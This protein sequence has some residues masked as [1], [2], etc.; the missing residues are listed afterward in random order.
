MSEHAYTNHLINETSPYLLQHAHNP[1]DWYPWGEEAL[2]R[3]HTEDKP[4][5]LSIGYS[6]CHWCHVMEHESFEDPR[7][8][9][10]MN[11]HFVNIKVDREERPDLDAIYMQAVQAMTGQGGWPMTTFLTPQGQPFYGGT[12]YPPEPRH[13]LPG[14]TQLLKHINNLWQTRR[15]EV[16]ET[17]GQ[18]A[19]TLQASLQIAG[20]AQPLDPSI[21]DQAYAVLPERYDRRYGGWGNAPKFP[22]PQT[23][24]FVLRHYLRTGD[25]DGLAMAVHTLDTMARGGMYDQLG[26]GFHRYSVDERWLVPHFE[27]MLYD[28]AQ[29]ARV[30]LHAYQITG[31]AFYRRIVEETLDYV[32]REMTAPEGGFYATQ[33]A[34][35]EGEEGKFFVWTADEVRSVLGLDALRWMQLY[36]V[37]T[38]GN[39]EGKTILNLPRPLEEVARVLG[40]RPAQLE[41]L[42]ARGRAK[43]FAVREQ[44]VHPGRD[45]KVLVAWNG[46]MLAAM[47]EVGRVL[48]RDDYIRA[49]KHNAEFVLGTL[50]HDGQ[51]WHVY[52]D[53]QAKI[54]GF[55]EDY[56]L[57][58]DGLLALYHAT[59]EMRY[60]DQAQQFAG[61][62]VEHFWDKDGGGFF[63]TSDVAETLIARPKD[64]FDEAVPSANG[65]AAQVLQRLSV[66]F[67]TADDSRRAQAII[68][69]VAPAL[70]KYPTALGSMLNALDTI[71]QVSQEV[72]IIGH[73]EQEDTRALLAVL[74]R[75]YLPHTVVALAEPNDA[76]LQARIPLLAERPQRH[77]KA[78]AYACQNYA[79]QQPTTQPEELEQQIAGAQ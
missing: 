39:W 55:A 59:F 25:K 77:G 68:E 3:A 73:F 5:L 18:M 21:L 63:Q 71:L 34:D 11:A 40:T 33:D 50:L 46:L 58:A 37:S 13:G 1:V 48:G 79:C 22:Q 30:Y 27:K 65:M 64:L 7:V 24:E 76:A 43:L 44:R 19:Q 52:K 23:I 9:E 41:E 29:L 72:V 6:A 17:A 66:L 53:G 35:S 8:A 12:Y 47:A 42:A 67:D 56:A 31:N 49:A 36:D 32:I 78:T 60:L 75:H 62:L 74:N 70:T 20:D 15:D 61:Y 2:A 69:L 16:V 54:D 57:Y 45:D 38:R 4:I 51:L 28:N 26:G 10:I 14:F